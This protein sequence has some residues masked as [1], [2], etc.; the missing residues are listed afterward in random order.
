M[1]FYFAREL[2]YAGRWDRCREA[3]VDFLALPNGWAAERCEAYRILAA[4][5]DDPE[6]WMWKA[7]GECPARREP[8]V[9]LCR[10]AVSV[11]ERERAQ[12]LFAEAWTRTRDDLYTTD[13][14]A[15]GESMTK[16]AEQIEEM[17]VHA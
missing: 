1:A 3:M 4:I 16:L 6:R 10:F 17:S 7:V 2:W 8:W 11:G 15:W 13:P 5:D 14:G 12:F 9:D